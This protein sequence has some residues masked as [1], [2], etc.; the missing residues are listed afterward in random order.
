MLM[1]FIQ[2]SLSRNNERH[3]SYSNNKAD[4]KS[5]GH[6]YAS[7]VRRAYSRCNC[8]DPGEFKTGMFNT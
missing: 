4:S 8:I 6:A 3:Y 5:I 2:C 1:R 7:S